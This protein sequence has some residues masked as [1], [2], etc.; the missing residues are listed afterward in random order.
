[1]KDQHERGTEATNDVSPMLKSQDPMRDQLKDEEPMRRWLN[2]GKPMR[3]KG[4]A[5]SVTNASEES[6]KRLCMA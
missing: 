3:E 2:I 6:T 4:V 1:M 5:E